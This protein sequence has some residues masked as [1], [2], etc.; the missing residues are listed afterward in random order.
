MKSVLMAGALAL[1][2][3]LP[4]AAGDLS[5]AG[6]P[7]A[8]RERVEQLEFEHSTPSEGRVFASD[9]GVVSATVSPIAA[10]AGVQTLKSGG[11]A[12]DAATTVALTQIT[13]QL[14]SVV[15]YA[16]IITGLYYEAK[17]GKVYSFDGGYNSYLGETDPATIPV[18]DLGPLNFGGPKPTIGG[19]KGRETLVPGFM[20]GLEALHGRFGR[21]PFKDL[22]APALYYDEQG[23][24]ISATHDRFLKLRQSFLAR[25]PEGRA[26]M[27]QA[28][29]E[30]PAVGALFRQPDLAKTLRGVAAQ[31]S[32]YMYTGAW[33]QEFV[34]VVQREG[35]KVTSEDMARYVVSWNEPHKQDVLGASVYVNGGQHYGAYYL[36]PALNLAEAKTLQT[37]GPYWSDPDAF[38]Q[39]SRINEAVTAAPDLNPQ[40]AAFLRSKGVDV[41][42]EHQ[43]TKAYAAQV[44]PLI[45]AMFGVSD[46]NVPRHS[47]S[48]VVVDKDG[49]VAAVTHTINSVIWGDTG[50][51]VG[52]VPIPDSAAFQQARLAKMK[53]GD[54]LPHE[55]IDTIAVKNGKPV[56]ATAAIGSSLVPETIRTLVGVLGQERDLNQIMSAPPLLSTFDL[57]AKPKAPGSNPVMVPKGRYE[58]AF[59]AKLR[60]L[61]LQVT[62]VDPAMAQGLR[63]TLTAVRIDPK[64]G[65]RTAADVPGVAVFNAV[66]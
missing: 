8:E 7:K 30:T 15:S 46:V 4:A 65:E 29:G 3:S 31:G 19:A 39:L 5:P 35:G 33:G 57:S 54:R 55:I 37:R 10:Y 62:E 61:G 17:T 21:L 43:L 63:G 11:N 38:V 41:S 23:V 56:L 12:A 26:F 36:L 42:P 32:A 1:S 14:G 40:V 24:R 27:A 28:G 9:G 16:G 64:T 2:T 6:W 66:Q 47:N 49:N 25:T 48:I 60:A 58:E 18:G 45:D 50:I 34:R 22:F 20:A 59:L 51:V 52:G 13:T 44:A 53:P